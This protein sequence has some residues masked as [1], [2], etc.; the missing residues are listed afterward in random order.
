MKQ[1]I[2][3]RLNKWT[4]CLCFTFG[5]SCLEQADGPTNAWTAALVDRGPFIL[6]DNLNIK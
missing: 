1:K 6:V 3:T 2:Y 5:I 4:F